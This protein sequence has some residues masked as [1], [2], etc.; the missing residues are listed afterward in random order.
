MKLHEPINENNFFTCTTTCQDCIL[1]LLKVNMF[2]CPFMYIPIRNQ[3]KRKLVYKK[4]K[5]QIMF[6]LLEDNK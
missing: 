4:L 1:S 5:L 6:L 3:E 2:I